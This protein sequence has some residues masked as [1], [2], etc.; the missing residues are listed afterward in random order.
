[1]QATRNLTVDAVVLGARVAAK[2]LSW[3]RAVVTRRE[4]HCK[5]AL[6]LGD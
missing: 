4:F 3:H 1:M 2:A 6:R 5:T